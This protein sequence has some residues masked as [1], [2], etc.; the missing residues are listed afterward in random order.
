MATSP[1]TDNS[2]NP[3]LRTWVPGGNDNTL[4]PIQ[5]LP[6]CVFLDPEDEYPSLG[7][8]IG[9]S[10][11]NLNMLHEAGLI[12]DS[13]HHDHDVCDAFEMPMLNGLLGLPAAKRREI[14]GQIQKFLLEGPPGGQSVRRVREKCL[15]AID[16]TQ[17]LIPMLVPNYTDFY[18]S[19]HHATNVGSM[20]RP[21]NPLL[22]NYKHVPIGYHGRA[23]SIVVSGTPIKRPKGQQSPP[24]NDPSQGPS[25][26]PCK[27]LDYELELGAVIGDVNELGEPVSIANARE[28]IAGLTIVNDWSARDVQKWEYQPLGPFLAK[29]FATSIAPYITPIEALEPFRCAL[30]ARASGD[31]RPLPYLFDETDQREGGFDIRLE[32]LLRT[33]QMRE[34]DAPAHTISRGNFR[35]MYWTFAQMVAHHTCNGCNLM[36]GDLLASGTISGPDASSRG[37]LLELS[38]DGIDPTTNKPKPRKPLALPTGEQRTFLQDGDEVTMRA[39]CERAGY[40]T[41]SLGEVVGVIEG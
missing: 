27:M 15:I 23:S 17:L 24:D 22:P 11:V 21:D 29:N 14:R 8:R 34:A 3:A 1:S 18:A 20:F 26:G 16:D 40:R 2:T 5:N 35:H 32:V 28:R 12:G 37:C 31:P 7:V 10:I 41:I 33:R 39:V 36:P 13:E 19:I 38:W 9:E 25:F 4:F 30:E 6:Y